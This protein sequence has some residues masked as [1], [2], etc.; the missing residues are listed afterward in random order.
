M[1]QTRGGVR[2][3]AEVA[4]SICHK[5]SLNSSMIVSMKSLDIPGPV[6]IKSA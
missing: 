2:K 6:L 5:F 1:P 3:E 4:S